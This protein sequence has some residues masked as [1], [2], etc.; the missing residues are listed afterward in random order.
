MLCDIFEER[1]AFRDLK[2][3]RRHSS[4]GSATIQTDLSNP[5]I[6]DMIVRCIV[7]LRQLI[8]TEPF[9]TDYVFKKNEALEF[10]KVLGTILININ[11]K[12]KHN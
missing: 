2:A 3:V 11:K 7:T 10:D 1:Y 6:V 8:K 12:I 5:H 9:I 4:P